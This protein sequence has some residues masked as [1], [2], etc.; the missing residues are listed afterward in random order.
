V[1]LQRASP[2][3]PEDAICECARAECSETIT[4]TALEYEELR[5]HSTWFAVAPLDAHCV[6]EVERIVTKSENYWVVEKLDEAGAVA[7]RLDP[8][9]R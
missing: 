1:N 7:E 4:I 9:S 6:P 8:R 5:S 2:D 3:L